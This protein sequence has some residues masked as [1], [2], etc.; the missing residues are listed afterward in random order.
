MNKTT[1]VQSEPI[2]IYFG[3]KTCSLMRTDFLIWR[4]RTWKPSSEGCSC[5]TQLLLA[6][7]REASLLPLPAQGD[8]AGWGASKGRSWSSARS[9][10]KWVWVMQE[11]EHEQGQVEASCPHRSGVWHL[12]NRR[13]WE[14]S[15]G[16]ETWRSHEGQL[17]AALAGTTLTSAFPLRWAS[18]AMPSLFLGTSRQGTKS[19]Q[20]S[21]ECLELLWAGGGCRC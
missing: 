11:Q 5:S 15:H 1:H 9:L 16:W 18:P 10:V 3:E 13:L 21:E 6:V 8:P 4:S 19:T 7:W 12:G 20:L 2:L 14:G 17:G